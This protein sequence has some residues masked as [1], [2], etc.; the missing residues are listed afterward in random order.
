MKTKIIII[1]LLVMIPILAASQWQFQNP[2]P[3]NAPLNDIFFIDANHGWAVGDYGTIL[4]TENGGVSWIEQHS[5]Q[6]MPSNQFTEFYNIHFTDTDN[7]W[8][9]GHCFLHEEAEYGIIYKTDNGGNSW[10]EEYAKLNEVIKDIS[11]VN[12]DTGW[13]VGYNVVEEFGIILCTKNGGETWEVQYDDENEILNK[14]CFVGSGNG[15]AVGNDGLILHTSDLGENWEEQQ[16]NV[17]VN[18][19]GICFTDLYH[20]WIAGDMRSSPDQGKIMYTQDGGET[21]WVNYEVGGYTDV[22]DIFFID[23][24]G[25]VACDFRHASIQSSGFLITNDGGITWTH[26]YDLGII[27]D[28]LSSVFFLDSITGWATGENVIINSTNKGNSWVLQNSLSNTN[29]VDVCFIDQENGWALGSKFVWAGSPSVCEGT[30]LYTNNG[31][32]SWQEIFRD[33]IIGYSF[34]SMFFIDLNYGWVVGDFLYADL[35][36]TT[37]GGF[38]WNSIS[39]QF[40]D[41]PNSVFFIDSLNGWITTGSSNRWKNIY[42]AIYYSYN[43]GYSWTEQ[44]NAGYESS[45]NSLFFIDNS[46]GWAVGRDTT[47]KGLILHTIDGGVKWEIQLSGIYKQLHSVTFN[48]AYRGWA[49]GDSGTILST[50]DGGKN[51]I[52]QDCPPEYSHFS[53]KSVNF[54]DDAVGWIAG[55]YNDH[56]PHFASGSILIRSGDGGKTWQ[57]Q[58]NRPYSGLTSVQFTDIENG[59]AVGYGGTILHSDSGGIT[60]QEEISAPPK[61]IP[62]DVYPNPACGISDIRYQIPD[63]RFVRLEVF[64]INGQ[65]IRTLV[66]E[67]QAAGDYVVR[68]DGADLP[69]GIYAVKLQVDNKS[70]TL[71]LLL[72]K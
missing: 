6:N 67:M 44:Y 11:F 45:I 14:L 7:G 41:F 5:N 33:F 9:V 68:F 46:E 28:Q 31:G 49:V 69:A 63:I 3:T 30:I 15:W 8:T 57:E 37:D 43:G 38:T 61:E 65:K 19:S 66:E 27:L 25:W 40:N 24:N 29:L 70:E 58:F 10:E 42:G 26:Q 12:Q 39:G 52:L 62:L 16:S 4:Y 72:M 60:W 35:V 71:K 59:W 36:K 2:V 55:G 53:F 48:N 13:A 51:W 32:E 20:G 47:I 1:S 64:D 34:N 56:Y 23:N 18:F 21:W 22:K 54:P 17:T 50:I